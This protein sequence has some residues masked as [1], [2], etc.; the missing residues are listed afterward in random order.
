MYNRCYIAYKANKDYIQGEDMA[1]ILIRNIPTE[2]R[3]NVKT[4][5][6]I[7]KKTMQSAIMGL[8]EDYVKPLPAF[9]GQNAA[10]CPVNGPPDKKT[11]AASLAFQAGNERD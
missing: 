4:M 11:R 1:D 5:A 8:L 2:L 6:S 3:D 7:E 10:H 9:L